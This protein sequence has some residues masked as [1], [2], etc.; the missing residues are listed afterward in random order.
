MA[1]NGI[2][3]AYHV[4][5]N[6]E[7]QLINDARHRIPNVGKNLFVVKD[8]QVAVDYNCAQLFIDL[9]LVKD[10]SPDPSYVE[11]FHRVFV[12]NTVENENMFTVDKEMVP[13]LT[14]PYPEKFDLRAML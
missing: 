2:R 8:P 11:G 10:R 9:P 1:F 7:H 6:D 12:I 3:V 14:D 4:E 13:S 5:N